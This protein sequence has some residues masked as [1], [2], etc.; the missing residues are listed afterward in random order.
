[1]NISKSAAACSI[2]TRRCCRCRWRATARSAFEK[3]AEK[4]QRAREREALQQSPDQPDAADSAAGVA[5]YAQRASLGDTVRFMRPYEREVLRY[6]LQVR[7]AL[8]V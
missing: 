4:A 8:P 6:A 3:E 7:H 2:P 1:M 5:R